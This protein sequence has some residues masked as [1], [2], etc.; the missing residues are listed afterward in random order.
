MFCERQQLKLIQDEAASGTYR[1]VFA[2]ALNDAAEA[3]GI[4]GKTGR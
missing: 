3:S 4:G 2:G 1:G